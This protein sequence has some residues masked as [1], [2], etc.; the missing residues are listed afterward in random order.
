MLDCIQ[1]VCINTLQHTTSPS[2]TD[3]NKKREAKIMCAF[4]NSKYKW[5]GTTYVS[6]TFE[7]DNKKKIENGGLGRTFKQS[8]HLEP[9]QNKAVQFNT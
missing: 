2:S 3:A 7:S 4:L 6:F 5:A 9:L 1:G 8:N